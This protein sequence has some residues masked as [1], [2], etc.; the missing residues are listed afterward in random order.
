MASRP[1]THAHETLSSA[2]RLSAP[3]VVHDDGS[4]RFRPGLAVRGRVLLACAAVLVVLWSVRK[5][6]GPDGTAEASLVHA[7][8]TRGLFASERDV[9]WLEPPQGALALRSALV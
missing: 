1:T 8:G 5:P 7:L 4:R 3:V 6:L 9:V 2:G